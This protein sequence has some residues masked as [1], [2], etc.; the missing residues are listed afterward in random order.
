MPPNVV[1]ISGKEQKRSIGGESLRKEEVRIIPLSLGRVNVEVEIESES[2]KK[3]G[4]D[5]TS[6]FRQA[7]FSS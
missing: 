1:N 2:E 5:H 7:Q 3:R 6:V 4:E